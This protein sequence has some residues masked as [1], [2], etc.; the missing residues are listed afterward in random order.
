[1]RWHRAQTRTSRT[2][3]VS[4]DN[5][6]ILLKSEIARIAARQIRV[7]TKRLKSVAG[8]YRSEIAALK[9]R[10]VALEQ[11]I[12]RLAKGAPRQTKKRAGDDGTGSLRFAAKGFAS[13]RRRLGPS[14]D[15]FGAVGRFA[16]G[17]RADRILEKVICLR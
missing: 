2:H 1:M 14:V 9:R 12:K 5:I 8:Q 6:A 15:S 16:S 3:Q 10:V 7:E 13:H 11:Q 4:N 17:R